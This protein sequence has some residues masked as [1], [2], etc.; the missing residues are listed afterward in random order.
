MKPNKIQNHFNEQWLP[1]ETKAP[2]K[3]FDYFFS[4]YGRLKS[5]NKVTGAERL[6]KGSVMK[7]GFLQLNLTLQDNVRQGFYVHKLVGESFLKEPPKEKKFLIHLDGNKM[8]NYW[9]NLKWVNQRELTD[10]QIEQGV[11][12]PENR[13]TSRLVKMTESKVRLLKKRLREGKT[14]RSILAKSF[15]ITQTQLKRIESGENWGRVE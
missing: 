15:G 2:T 7:Q 14:K 5:V 1:V 10:I 11:Y 12:D 13:K 9:K 8:N 6:L 3:G 4:D